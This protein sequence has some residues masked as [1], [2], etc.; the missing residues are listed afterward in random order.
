MAGGRRLGGPIH[1]LGGRERDF[2]QGLA[3]GG[4]EHRQ[5]VP[6]LDLDP[7][8]VDEVLGLLHQITS[9]G[10]VRLAG[11]EKGLQRPLRGRIGL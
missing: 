9:N 7:L 11:A 1:I 3:G 4:V 2:A 8:T 6:P 5:L 10:L